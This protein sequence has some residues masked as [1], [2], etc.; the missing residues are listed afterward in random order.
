MICIPLLLFKVI[1]SLMS[2][3][4]QFGGKQGRLSWHLMG[5]Y[6][7][8][9]R[10]GLSQ[11]C[12]PQWTQWPGLCGLFDHRCSVGGTYWK[13]ARPNIRTLKFKRKNKY[14]CELRF[15]CLLSMDLET[16]FRV[17]AGDHKDSDILKQWISFFSLSS[18]PFLSLSIKTYET[19]TICQALF[20][21]V[22][23][24]LII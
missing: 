12:D 16:V 22:Y 1:F 18:S 15:L 8:A 2:W 17:P 4:F 3:K 11:T 19:F 10:T 6:K 7:Q 14:L 24:Y 23:V 5:D 13:V 21:A 20:L 9:V